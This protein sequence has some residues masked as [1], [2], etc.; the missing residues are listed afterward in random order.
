M[1]LRS[2]LIVGAFGLAVA[3]PS[4]A[5]ETAANVTTTVATAPAVQ[6]ANKA[7]PK[8][9]DKANKHMAEKTGTPVNIN[10][11]DAQDISKSLKGIGKK[12]AEAIVAYRTKNG[13]FKSVDDLTNVKGIS[14]KVIEK[15]NGKILLG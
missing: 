12:R 8:V 7:A 13:P 10:T 3:A 15:N 6:A 11:A 5:E 1:R 4:F 9:A 2:L 14:K